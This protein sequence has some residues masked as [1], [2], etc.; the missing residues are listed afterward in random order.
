MDTKIPVEDVLAGEPIPVGVGEIDKELVTLWQATAQVP[1]DEARMAVTLVRVL[2]LITYVEGDDRADEI[3]NVIR[4]ITGRHPCRSI[5]LICRGN[6][7]APGK[8]SAW[9]SAHCQLPS[10]SGK[11]ICSEQISIAAEGKAVPTMYALAMELLISDTPVFLWWTSSQPF[12][13]QLL[14]HLSDSIDRLIVDS[15]VF[16]EPVPSLLK[17]AGIGDSIR[18]APLRR[19]MSDF[20]WTRLTPWREITAQ[21]FDLPATRRY[22]HGITSLEIDYAQPDPGQPANPVQALLYAGWMASRLDWKFEGAVQ[23]NDNSIFE[24]HL[25]RDGHPVVITARPVPADCKTPGGI[26]DARLH[27]TRPG[28]ADFGITCHAAEQ[29]A[30]S[31]VS[32]G[33]AAPTVRT[34]IYVEPDEAELLNQELEMFDHDKIYEQALH[35]AALAARGS[36]P[37]QRWSIMA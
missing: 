25:L 1:A 27:A 30:T 7:N 11:Q 21:F 29:Y 26:V 24:L 36:E 4:R 20:N 33:G 35:M 22:M 8:M 2:N 17:M 28:Q 19:A 12:E 34:M 6:D 3:N 14:S 9:I 16:K 23:G 18:Q 32:L 15:A 5:M 37:S 31:S 10:E 13:D